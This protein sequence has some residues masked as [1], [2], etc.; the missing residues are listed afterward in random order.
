MHRREFLNLIGTGASLAVMPSFARLLPDPPDATLHISPVELEIA[1]GKTIKTIGYNGSAPGPVL[2]FREGQ[3]VTI[4]V[5]ND[6]KEPE[7]VHWHGLFIPPEVDGSAEEGTP[8]IPPKT[9]QRYSFVVAPS[10]TRWYH[11]HVSAGRNLER[12]T[13]TGQFGMLYIE[14]KNE[15]GQYDAEFA[16]CL[17]GWK[18]YLDNSSGEGSLEPAYNLFSVNSHALGHG[19]P[20]RVRQ[21]QRALFRILNA[22]ATMHHQVAFAGH[23]FEVVSL[24]GNA[25]PTPR[26][27][28]VLSLGPA[29]RVDAIVTMNAPGVWILGE[30]DDQLRKLGLGV[31]VE[32]E[33]RKESPRWIAPAKVEWD[34]TIFGSPAENPSGNSQVGQPPFEILP[35]VFRRK[36]AGN[37]WVDHWT[38]NDKEYAK[39]EPIMIR[40]NHRYRLRFD[41]Q[42]DDDHPVHLHRHS[43]ELKNVADKS[44][45]GI[46]KDTVV[47][48]H[49]QIVEVDLLANHPGATLFHCHQQ[50]HMDFGF[51]ALFRY[52]S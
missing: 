49:R 20:I 6:T 21:G 33:N 24:D 36:F 30:V 17:H 44:T 45:A 41:N 15:P 38:I 34:Y 37:N 43:F 19:E 46:M 8:Y 32:Y 39:S 18:P 51:M 29:E 42:S 26:K 1:L 23:E 31:V 11:T 7:L 13:Y 12:S 10:G 5:F 25:V 4:Q 2:R 50:M 48:P 9:S 35:L 14:P 40:E 3:R 47:V 52:A 22:N 27:V 16:L 28:D